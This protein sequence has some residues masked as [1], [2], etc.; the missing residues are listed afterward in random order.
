MKLFLADVHLYR[1]RL[2]GVMKDEGGGMIYPWDKD[3]NG[4]PRGPK[5]DLDAAEKLINE[6]GYHRRDEELADAREASKNW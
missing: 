5:D 1:A 4:K 2:F 6:C 3:P